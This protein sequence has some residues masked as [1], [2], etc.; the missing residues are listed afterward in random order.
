MS[1]ANN[2]DPHEE[3]ASFEMRT[4]MI[5][6]DYLI[7]A[8]EIAHRS[9]C[10]IERDGLAIFA[11]GCAIEVNLAD[12]IAQEPDVIPRLLHA[13]ASR[14]PKS[15]HR[16]V[17]VAA[18]PY[19]LR[20]LCSFSV[21]EITVVD[22]EG[23]PPF[24]IFIG[25]QGQIGEIWA[26]DLIAE[27]AA[28][29]RDEQ[30]SP[31]NF[32]LDPVIGHEKFRKKVADAIVAIEDQRLKKV[33]LAREVVIN[34]DR[35]FLQHELLGRLRALH[36]SCLS[37]AIHGFVGATPELLLRKSDHQSIS[38]LLA[39]T[40]AR[41]GDPEEDRRLA[42]SLLSSRKER[43]E[44][45]YVVDEI[46]DNLRS[47]TDSVS[48]PDGPHILE[49]RNVIHLAT[50]IIATN[51]ASSV[52]SLE[53]ACKLHPTPAICG[54]PRL[55]AAA[56]I[57]EHEGLSRDLYAGLVGYMGADGDGEWWIGIR[58]AMIEG[59]T[60]RML[61]GVGIVA[62]SDPATEFAETQ[63]KLQAMLAILVRP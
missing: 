7:A 49:L 3:V 9:G 13:I 8:R 37:F 4:R 33:V 16:P 50:T 23:S 22:R 26:R 20:A 46:R 18:F 32:S 5:N 39:G 51:I 42:K 11:L 31:E 24:A 43:E 63:L 36:P 57:Q 48:V 30:G 62:D 53:V 1:P 14:S 45:Q 61:A 35:P 34:A 19:D 44:H 25:R 27:A 12:G 59:A 21:A 2:P 40:M 56:Y 38:I 15:E 52:T 17:V 55:Q 60:A 47:F 6:R 54:T 28:Q 29:H 41:S 10:V 58:S